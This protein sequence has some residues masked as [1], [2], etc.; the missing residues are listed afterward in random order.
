MARKRQQSQTKREFKRVFRRANKHYPQYLNKFLSSQ[1]GKAFMFDVMS[2]LI[3]GFIVSNKT[4]D[5]E[6]IIDDEAIIYLSSDV[7]DYQPNGDR[8]FKQRRSNYRYEG[9]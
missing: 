8:F 3:D 4:E 2:Q 7:E 9:K 6:V 5:M 1:E